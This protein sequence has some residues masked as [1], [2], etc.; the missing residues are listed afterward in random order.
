MNSPSTELT[1][2]RPRSRALNAL[3][4]V[5]ASLFVAD[6][7][8]S[9]HFIGNSWLVVVRWAALILIALGGLRKA[10]LTFWILFA[11]LV[12]GEIGADR[13]QFAEHLRFLSD[14]FLRLIQV[15]V[16][17]LILGSLIS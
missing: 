15:I 11:M 13:P 8:L 12:G 2:R 17:P 16:A 4:V 7:V 14:I 3:I 5:G 6:A 9:A 10:S 1:A